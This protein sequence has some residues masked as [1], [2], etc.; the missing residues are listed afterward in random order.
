MAGIRSQS[1]Q[2]HRSWK[3]PRLLLVGTA[4]LW[5]KRHPRLRHRILSAFAIVV[6]V[7]VCMWAYTHWHDPDRDFKLW[8][9]LAAF[10]PFGISVFVAFIPAMEKSKRMRP[11]WRLLIVGIGLCY[12]M[13]LWHQQTVNLFSSRND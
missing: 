10:C 13:I 3:A 9:F 12:S 11:L 6:T 8:N 5:R 7:G 2:T 1:S 4:E